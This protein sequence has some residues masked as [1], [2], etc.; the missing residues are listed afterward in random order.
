MEYRK[1]LMLA[2]MNL[3][4]SGCSHSPTKKMSQPEAPGQTQT[5]YSLEEFNKDLSP[6]LPTVD[7]FI[8]HIDGSRITWEELKEQIIFAKDAFSK[9]GVQLNIVS[10]KRVQVPEAW[11]VLKGIEPTVNPKFFKDDLDAYERIEQKKKIL[12][13]ESAKILSSIVG[14]LPNS[15]RL[16]HVVTLKDALYS[17]YEKEGEN[18]EYKTIEIGGLSLAPYSLQDRIP[19]TIRGVILIIK[20]KNQFNLGHELGHKLI[21][22]SHEGLNICPKFSGKTVPGLM[23]YSGESQIYEGKKGRWHRERL[24]LSP[25]LYRMIDGKK[26]WNE[27]FKLDGRYS[28]PIY[29]SYVMKPS[30]KSAE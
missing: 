19:K 29:G 21:N 9:V 12:P 17:F 26:T 15:E 13:M 24:L 20:G 27:D 5:S 18:W 11:K 8:H 10:A 22:T 7:I 30:C 25:F 14:K 28:D 3:A 2:A 1:L 23:G 4:I 16:I 6:G